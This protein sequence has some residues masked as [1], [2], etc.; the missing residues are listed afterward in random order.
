MIRRRPLDEG[1]DA[2][3]YAL[4][5]VFNPWAYRRSIPITFQ[6]EVDLGSFQR[7]SGN[8]ANKLVWYGEV[9]WQARN[10]L[11]LL[12]AY[13]W[14]DPDRDVVDDDSGRVSGGA[15]VTIY[16]GVTLDGRVRYLHVATPTGSATDLFMQ[17]HL[18]F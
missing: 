18:W 8:N 16:P 2:D 3:S 12:V 14:A 15:Q 1:G 5:G 13:D 7:A 11:N 4:Y 9:D 17:I 6:G 10:G